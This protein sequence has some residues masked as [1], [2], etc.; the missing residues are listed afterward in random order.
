MKVAILNSYKKINVRL[1]NEIESLQSSGHIV[2]VFLLDRGNNRE[3][4]F[5]NEELTAHVYKIGL[6]FPLK[7][8]S[9]LCYL[10]IVYM[11]L[12][13]TLLNHEYD[14]LH[15][16]HPVFLPLALIIG[17]IKKCKIL[18]DCFELH[19]VSFFY[20]LP[21][22]IR[23]KP[24]IKLGEYLEEKMVCCVDGVITID[25]ADDYLIKRYKKANQKVVA[26]Y[27]VPDLNVE[28]DDDLLEELKRKYWNR[29]IVSCI[30][31]I[32]RAKCIKE[33]VEAANILRDI[34]PE[35]K[36]F[37]IGT[38]R[39]D[40]EDE[41]IKYITLH[42]L[43]TNIQFTGWESYK[44]MLSYLAIS[45]A[46]LALYR[47][48]PHY[49]LSRGNAR[50]IFTYMS[51]SVPV[52]ASKFGEIGKI[53]YETD[54]GLIVDPADAREIAEALKYLLENPEKARAMGAN[55]RKAIEEEFN[56]EREQDKLLRVYDQ[57]SRVYNYLGP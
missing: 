56:W 10:P 37:F 24:L 40:C 55:G 28:P 14:V 20:R 25:T 38:I 48:L 9:F 42:K 50:R 30:G 11:C 21:K 5:E 32:S 22:R 13:K 39:D 8:A 57:L 47:P 35:I 2:N 43:E 27:N 4:S 31:G 3:V 53:V 19:S 23:L 1:R 41:I 17:K 52:I 45:D 6:N 49:L 44:R 16:C 33:M 46:G 12:F 51:L 36:F 7:A 18:Y 34:F 54:C 15:I 26:L 29:K